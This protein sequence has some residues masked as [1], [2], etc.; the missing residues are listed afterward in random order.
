MGLPDS[1]LKKIVKVGISEYAISTDPNDMLVTYSLGSCV[2][3]TFY[4]PVVK[5]GGMIHCM[6]PNV[7]TQKQTSEINPVMYVD[8]GVIILLQKL[9]DLGASRKKLICK[10]AGC[11][12]SI[13]NTEDL[14]KIGERNYM[15]LRKVLWKNGI[16]IRGELIGG[17]DPKTMYLEIDSGHV[18]VKNGKEK[19]SL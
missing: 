17:P 9:F 14:F 4:D 19:I 6:L 16:I 12:T 2:G 7:N 1:N 13:K 15:M 10:V 11:G 5:I 18:E 8:T 3:V